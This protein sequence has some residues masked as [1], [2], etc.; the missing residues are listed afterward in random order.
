MVSVASWAHRAL[1]GIPRYHH[2]RDEPDYCQRFASWAREEVVGVYQNPTPAEPSS[3]VITDRGLYWPSADTMQCLE[4]ANL[5]SVRGPG[6]KG[7]GAELKV[8]LL[9][10]T[11]RVIRIEGGDGKYRDVYSMVRFIDRVIELKHKE[12]LG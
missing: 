2:Y 6:E 12:G 8:E 1:R 4:F 7:G 9:D 10:G 11:S 5:R 3:I